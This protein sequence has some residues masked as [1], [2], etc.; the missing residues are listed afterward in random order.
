MCG[1]LEIDRGI[2][3]DSSSGSAAAVE[4]SE[5]N[6]EA[7]RNSTDWHRQ[8]ISARRRGRT[9]LLNF[10]AM[11]ILFS[12]HHGAMVSCV[13]FSTVYLGSTGAWELALFHLVYGLSALSGSTYVVK[14]LGARNSMVVGMAMC[15]VYV[16]CFWC[17]LRWQSTTTAQAWF[18]ALIGG[19]G[20]GLVWTGQGCY[21]ARAAEKYA[22]TVGKS[23]EACT[24]HLSG[25]FAFMYLLE[26]VLSKLLSWLLLGPLGMTPQSLILAYT[27]VVTFSTCLMA[28]VHDYRPTEAERR[29]QQQHHTQNGRYMFTAAWQLLRSDAKMKYMI[30]LNAVFGFA[31]P[32]INAYMN[33]EVVRRVVDTDQAVGLLSSTTSA[34][35]ALCSIAFGTVKHKG[36]ALIIGAFAFGLVAVPSMILPDPSHWTLNI[37]VAVY[38]LQGIGRSSFEGALKGT[39]ADF[40]PYEKEGAFANIILASGAFTSLGYF[41]AYNAPCVVQD[42]CVTFRDGTEHDILGLTM[43]IVISAV[44]AILGYWR[45]S[46]LHAQYSHPTD[47]R[48]GMGRALLAEQFVINDE[49]E[50]AAEEE[51]HSRDQEP[52]MAIPSPVPT[53]EDGYDTEQVGLTNDSTFNTDLS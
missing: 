52:N 49:E 5:Y 43:A 22:T 36:L 23:L 30:G 15:S 13:A 47:L 12:A 3:T 4:D 8:R 2:H 17:S 7:S 11:S 41:M 32:Y 18:G 44:A 35:A 31:S 10:A 38:V 9:I 20:I 39:F 45:A 25:A 19:S 42:F 40:F 26:E 48:V 24:S 27:F 6:D 53:G 16:V 14:T 50:A 46:V 21:F 34:V 37:L 28:S 51:R 29:R 33:G 1:C